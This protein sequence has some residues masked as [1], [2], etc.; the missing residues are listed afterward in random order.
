MTNDAYRLATKHIPHFGNWYCDARANVLAA[1]AEALNKA[2]PEGERFPLEGLTAADGDR[3]TGRRVRIWSGEHFAY[4]RQ[5]SGYTAQRAD[6]GL[7]DFVEAWRR[8]SHC[9]PQKRISLEVL[10]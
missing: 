10:P 8:V 4:W 7:F 3:F 2:A 6:A 5:G 9:C 1:I